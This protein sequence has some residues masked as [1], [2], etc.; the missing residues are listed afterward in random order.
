MPATTDTAAEGFAKILARC[1]GWPDKFSD[2]DAAALLEADDELVW[3]AIAWLRCHAHE[4]SFL[5]DMA[6]RTAAGERLS[7]AQLRGV[8]NHMR[9]Y[10]RARTANSNGRRHHE[11]AAPVPAPTGSGRT[12]AHAQGLEVVVLAW[13]NPSDGTSRLLGVFADNAAV[14]QFITSPEFRAWLADDEAWTRPASMRGWP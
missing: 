13:G 1:A 9:M 8:L 5:Q 3:G 4:N 12:T 10:G 2:S 11:R 6:A 14:D 7:P